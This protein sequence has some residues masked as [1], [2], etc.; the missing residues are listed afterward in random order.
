[1]KTGYIDRNNV[2]VNVGDYVACWDE[3][4]GIV[5]AMVTGFVKE[6]NGRFEVDGNELALGCAEYVEVE[7]VINGAKQNEQ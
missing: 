3:C 2:S 5:T 6:N 1:M 7:Q 4:D